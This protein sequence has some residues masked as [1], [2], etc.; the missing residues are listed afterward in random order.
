MNT[1]TV[2]TGDSLDVLKSLPDSSIE[3]VVTDPPLWARGHVAR[4]SRGVPAGVGEG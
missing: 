3:A 1:H 2:H 4:E